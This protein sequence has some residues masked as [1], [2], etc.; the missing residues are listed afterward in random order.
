MGSKKSFKCK[1]RHY[2]VPEAL[3]SKGDKE[4]KNSESIE[5][6]LQCMNR[7]RISIS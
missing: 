6:S 3:V 4:E 1:D 7:L 5:V 2:I